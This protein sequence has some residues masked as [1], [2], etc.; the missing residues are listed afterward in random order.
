MDDSFAFRWVYMDNG[1]KQ[2]VLPPINGYTRGQVIRPGHI[3]LLFEDT[4]P[5]KY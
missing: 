5:D 2:V 1:A 3:F 4:N